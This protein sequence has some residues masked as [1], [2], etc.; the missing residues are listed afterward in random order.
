MTSWTYDGV[1]DALYFR[2]AR[3]DVA[4]TVEVDE[5]TLM[6]D[7]DADGNCVGIEVLAVSRRL[8]V[9]TAALAGCNVAE[10]DLQMLASVVIAVRK[11]RSATSMGEGGVAPDTEHDNPTAVESSSARMLIPA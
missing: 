4:R 5:G 8:N 10:A 3:G 1:A 6:V 7:V 11:N 9:P 2:T